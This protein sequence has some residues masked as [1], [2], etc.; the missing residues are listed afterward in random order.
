MHAGGIALAAE[1][2][3]TIGDHLAGLRERRSR[4]FWLGFAAALTVHILAIFGV[5][6]APA[7][8]VGSPDGAQDAIAVEIVDGATLRDSM[9][10]PAPPPGAAASQQAPP[11]APPA[12]PA[13][14][15]PEVQPAPEQ[16]P[17]EVAALPEPSAP[18]P[19]ES[20]PAEAAQKSVT[21]LLPALDDAPAP[22]EAEK[23]AEPK[24]EKAEPQPKKTE[25][26]A[27]P[28]KKPPAKQAA[29]AQPRKRT[30]ALDLS[31]P[32]SDD[33]ASDSDPGSSA[34]TRPPG[35]TRSGE[36]DRFGRDVIRALQRSMP[37]ARAMARVTVRIVLNETGSRA[38]VTLLKSG[39][40]PDLD[41]D[42][43]FA[44]RQTAFPFPPR[45]ASVA[46]R[47]FNV[48]YIYR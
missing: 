45:N 12:E 17:A 3:S 48:T 5:G 35:I 27:T 6:S 31:M 29:K 47:T 36:N 40:N 28:A 25:A 11:P 32:G 37:R 24:E 1:G 18:P 9:E 2:A 23:K 13:E 19:P 42:V 34:V 20:P 33:G 46:D 8:T 14:A 10:P 15:Q 41:F 26:A 43:I 16:P 38:D 4:A 44:A 30:A 7:R 22:A 39:G 21:D